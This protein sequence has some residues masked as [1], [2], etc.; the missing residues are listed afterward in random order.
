MLPGAQQ[1]ASKA[2]LPAQDGFWSVLHC[3]DVAGVN[4]VRERQSRIVS[5]VS[6]RPAMAGVEI[7]AMKLTKKM[8]GIGDLYLHIRLLRSHENKNPFMPSCLA[9]WY[10]KCD[11]S[12]RHG[13]IKFGDACAVTCRS[14]KTNRRAREAVASGVT[15]G[16]APNVHKGN[17]CDKALAASSPNCAEDSD[18]S[19]DTLRFRQSKSSPELAKALFQALIGP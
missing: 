3:A 18:M 2:L 8:A 5:R 11:S 12:Q 15:S 4:R 1:R 10:L 7:H 6:I 17:A 13:R 14:E 19:D 16:R 9:S